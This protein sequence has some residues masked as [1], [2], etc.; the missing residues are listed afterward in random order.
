MLDRGDR[1]AL[2]RRRGVPRAARDRE[3][4]AAA[5]AA[6]RDRAEDRRLAPGL[7]RHRAHVRQRARDRA[8]EH[9]RRAS[10]TSSR[11]STSRS[12]TPRPGRRHACSSERRAVRGGGS[13]S[14]SLARRRGARR[15]RSRSPRRRRTSGRAGRHARGRA[16]RSRSPSTA[17]SRGA[18]R[19][20]P[21]RDG[22]P[23][24]DVAVLGGRPR[25]RARAPRGARLLRA[26]GT[27]GVT[28][29]ER[30][31]PDRLAL[32]RRSTSSG[33]SRSPTGSSGLAVAY[34]DVVDVNLKVWGDEWEQR[35]G[36]LTATLTAPGPRASARAGA[37]PSRCSGDVTID[38]RR[39]RSSARWTSRR[40]SS[41][42]SA[43]VFPRGA[44][45]RRP[46]ARRCEGQR[47]SRGSS[48]RRRPTRPPSSTTRSKIHDAIDHLRRTLLLLACSRL[49]PAL[50]VVCFAYWSLRARAQDGLR[51]RVRAGAAVRPRARA[52]PAAP[53]PAARRVGSNEFTAT[54]FDLIRAG[55]TRPS[56]SRPRRATWGGLR[57]EDVADLELVAG[58][59]SA[60]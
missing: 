49:V 3:L 58:Q 41:S 42:S 21:L 25:V 44:C 57:H 34:D 26:P 43:R 37:T 53:A 2:R 1:P 27:F 52:R 15:S 48:P 38:R 40:T 16:S 28:R 32:L 39:G 35:L 9:R 8:D 24:D 36:K 51:P 59:A 60:T 29:R 5:G 31:V 22:E 17:R 11:A 23:I 7:Q 14:R 47:A 10:S 56:R 6:R 18:Y 45:S 50:A 54:L 46:A 20:I 55:A 33:R 30:R 13:C 4:P 19:D 12:R